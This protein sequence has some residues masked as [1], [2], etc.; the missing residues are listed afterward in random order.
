MFGY[1]RHPQGGSD[2][3]GDKKIFEIAYHIEILVNFAV[4]S[5]EEEAEAA[6][7]S[8]HLL[9]VDFCPLNRYINLTN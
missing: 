5:D 8:Q 2:W 9:M 7:Q 4:D 1:T 6:S 3:E